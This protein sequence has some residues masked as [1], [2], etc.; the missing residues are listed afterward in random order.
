[1]RISNILGAASIAAVF[2]LSGCGKKGGGAEKEFEGYVNAICACK[3][4][5]C[6]T[7]EGQKYADK[8]K[9]DKPGKSDAKPSKKMIEL[10]A[11]MADCNKKIME[12]EM[13]KA[14]PPPPVEPPPTEPPPAADPAE[15]MKGEITALKD[16]L[17]ACADKACGDGVLKELDA[18]V[19]EA[20]TKFAN[21]TDDQKKFM[22][23][24]KAAVT[25]CAKKLK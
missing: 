3:D 5:K 10:T 9:N 24:T 12:E 22:D 4:M 8:H 25:D 23:E 1:M 15:A 6:I 13:K 18:K 14:T 2:A 11:K 17:C 16:K 21:P 7:D 20:K 19:A